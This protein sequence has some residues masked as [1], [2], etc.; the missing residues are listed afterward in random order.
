MPRDAPSQGQLFGQHVRSLRRAR[1]LTQIALAER[2]NLAADTIRR[3]E[4]GSF[5]PSLETLQKL[6]GGLGIQLSTLHLTFEGAE[7]VDDRQRREL[8][9]LI[10][11]QPPDRVALSLR[12]LRLLFEELDAC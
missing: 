9:D 12:L 8:L 3:L 10:V 6:C 7:H 2:S 11:M 1:G 5:S 4:N